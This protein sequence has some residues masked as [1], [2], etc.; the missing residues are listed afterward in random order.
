MSTDNYFRAGRQ[1]FF[2]DSSDEGSI[3]MA[4]DSACRVRRPAIFKPIKV[5][6]SWAG[7]D[8]V[9]MCPV[10]QRPEDPI[11]LDRWHAAR[12]MHE[13]MWASHTNHVL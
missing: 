3:T 6:G 2:F 8:I 13:K 9:G 12:S 10:G 11:D 7:C 5:H 1:V 4:W